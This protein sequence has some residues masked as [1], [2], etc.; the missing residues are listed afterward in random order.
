MKLFNST[1]KWKDWW[2][3]RKAD[4]KISYLDT[5]VHPHRKII[6]KMLQ[7]IPWFS[8]LEIGCNAAPNLV[9]IAKS[10]P[11]RQLGGIDVNPEAIE[12]AQQTFKNGF[13]KVNSAD[14][15][16]MSDKSV[17]VI[18]SDMCLI[19]VNPQDIGRYLKEIKR[20]ARNYVVLC[21]FHSDSLW[22]RLALKWN[23]GYNAYNWPK[24]LE[25]HGFY[26]VIS[27]KIKPEHWPESDLQQKFCY[28]ILAK[29]AKN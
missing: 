26:D 16:M 24:L 7:S 10:I 13:F 14:S 9:A 27:Y 11:N 5:F 20:V 18:L 12:L 1:T 2:T 8:L 29:I 28:I 23:E 22:N 3:K 19:Y 25:K 21:E 6:V 15:I 17:D 4:W